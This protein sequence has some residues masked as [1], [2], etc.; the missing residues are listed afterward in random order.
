MSLMMLLVNIGKQF[1]KVET[2]KGYL[3]LLPISVQMPPDLRGG[4][5]GWVHIGS[6]N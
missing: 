6:N 1:G 2:P 3:Y 4:A 5:G